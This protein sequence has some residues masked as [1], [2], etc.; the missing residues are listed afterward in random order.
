MSN[1][2]KVAEQFTQSFIK[3]PA[4]ENGEHRIDHLFE[5]AKKQ[6]SV[7]FGP[8]NC[9]H[10]FKAFG[11]KVY[12]DQTVLVEVVEDRARFVPTYVHLKSNHKEK[13]IHLVLRTR[14]MEKSVK[15][16][17]AGDSSN[18][19]Y[20][21]DE[22]TC[23]TNYL[24]DVVLI[25]EG[26]DFDP[27]GVF[28][29]VDA[30]TESDAVSY[31]EAITN[32][33]L[34]DSAFSKGIPDIRDHL[35]LLFTGLVDDKPFTYENRDIVVLPTHYKLAM[36]PEYINYG[37]FIPGDDDVWYEVSPDVGDDWC[38]PMA[39]IRIE[40]RLFV[41]GDLFL[42][43]DKCIAELKLFGFDLTQEAY[44]ALLNKAKSGARRKTNFGFNAS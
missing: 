3:C 1:N 13:P 39:Y 29:F 31:I 26:G 9:H 22:G 11:G 14:L 33:K 28:S 7:S 15:D 20:Y 36:I 12:A 2:L 18:L 37:I 10:C 6:G 27:H 34:E 25:A 35:G 41:S 17:R 43:R 24:R 19:Q 40:G 4:C 30:F 21:F 8:W 38:H 5:S 23:P 44:E 42:D 16:Q 32:T